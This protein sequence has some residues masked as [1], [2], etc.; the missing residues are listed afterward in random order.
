MFDV[1]AKL[2]TLGITPWIEPQAGMFLWCSL[3]DDL[4]AAD[5]A[6]AAL[7]KKI[8]LAP[9]NAFSPS[10]SATNY[11]RFNVSQMLD[12]QSFQVLGEALAREFRRHRP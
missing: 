4:D 5:I 2:R 6:R 11:M 3:P 10:Q 9:G 12:R 8:V 7:Q 1:S